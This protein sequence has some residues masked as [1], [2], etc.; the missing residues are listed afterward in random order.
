VLQ[1]E[2]KLKDNL[3]DEANTAIG[4]LEAQSDEKQ[5]TI[6]SLNRQLAEARH[7]L[8]EMAN[9]KSWQLTRPLRILTTLIQTSSVWAKIH[10]NHKD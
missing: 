10:G 2:I 9:S 7:E 6:V 3:V 8:Y 4:K 5:Q 1:N